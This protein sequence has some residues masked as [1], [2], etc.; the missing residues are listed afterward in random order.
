MK[1]GR[2][3]MSVRNFRRTS[4]P[5]HRAHAPAKPL[6]DTLEQRLLMSRAFG[7]DISQYQGTMNWTT[8]KNTG[9]SFV[10]MRASSSDFGANA[11]ANGN[12]PDTKFSTNAVNAKNAGVLYGVYHF[13][14]PTNNLQTAVQ[15]ADYFLSVA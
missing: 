7:C 15:Q 12:A 5:Q 13:G 10:L 9:A 11:D 2:R 1:W 3:R 8:Y 14:D 4:S 6:T